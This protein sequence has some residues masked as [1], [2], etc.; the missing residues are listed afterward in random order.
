MIVNCSELRAQF[1]VAIKDDDHVLLP[2][3]KAAEDKAKRYCGTVLEAEDITE[4]HDGD[5]TGVV[6]LRNFPVNS[7]A[8]VHDDIER[9]YDAASLVAATDYVVEACG[10]LTLDGLVFDP[11]FKNVKV[12]YNAGYSATVMPYDLKKAI[13]N[14]AFADYL[15][16]NGSINMVEGDEFVYRPK[17]LRDE[18]TAIL[19]QFKKMV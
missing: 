12:V 11:G 15:E 17:K 5:G 4:Y 9:S 6:L 2:L 1:K 3:L 13:A 18:A 14:I 7:V 8:T 10:K 19:D 16:A